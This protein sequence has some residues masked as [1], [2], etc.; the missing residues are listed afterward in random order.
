MMA[1]GG[2]RAVL[3]LAILPLL[4]AQAAETFIEIAPGPGSGRVLIAANQIVRI[5]R[6]GD[7]T[8]VDTAAWVQQRTV[9]PVETLARRVAETGQRLV[10]LTDLNGQRISIADARVVPVRE[11]QDRHAAGARA[12]IVMVGLRFNS[13]VAVREA[14]EDVLAALRSASAPR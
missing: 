4:A 7:H 10:P 12:A 9:E 2:R 13:D 5:G 11:S 1:R 6:A 14:P 3:A 8:V